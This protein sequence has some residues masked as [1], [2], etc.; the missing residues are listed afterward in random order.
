MRIGMSDEQRK[1]E[2]S[3][4]DAFYKHL[5]SGIPVAVDV[6]YEQPDFLA[7]YMTGRTE[8][9]K[10]LNLPLTMD[11]R[12][13]NIE[14][15]CQSNRGALSRAMDNL[16]DMCDQ[17]PWTENSRKQQ[18]AS[19]RKHYPP[20]IIKSVDKYKQGE[21]ST[22]SCTE[23]ESSKFV[24]TAIRNQC[25]NE[26]RNPS[27]FVQNNID[28]MMVIYSSERTDQILQ[29]DSDG[30]CSIVSFKHHSYQCPSLQDFDDMNPT[31]SKELNLVSRS[32]DIVDDANPF[33]ISVYESE[34]GIEM[35]SL[36]TSLTA[37]VTDSQESTNYGGCSQDDVTECEVHKIPLGE[38][39]VDNASATLSKTDLPRSTNV[40]GPNTIDAELID[41]PALSLEPNNDVSFDFCT[42]NSIQRRVLFPGV[43]G[44][45]TSND[46]NWK[47][48]NDSSIIQEVHT[49]TSIPAHSKLSDIQCMI[50]DIKDTI[51]AYKCHNESKLM[52]QISPNLDSP[53]LD[54]PVI[55]IDKSPHYNPTRIIDS[56][57]LG[58]PLSLITTPMVMDISLGEEKDNYIADPQCHDK[59]NVGRTGADEFMD[60][61]VDIDKKYN[62]QSVLLSE[63]QNFAVLKSFWCQKEKRESKRV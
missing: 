36:L 27:S 56:T 55:T 51:S 29:L 4:I 41:S 37:N 49:K 12:T 46:I 44:L 35:D 48:T 50:E 60:E 39:H 34:D 13:C 14:E 3:D 38:E 7:S 43:S 22:I 24:G 59:I 42:R 6:F 16:K 63:K 52:N 9:M 32:R 5:D 1:D 26:H 21:W 33:Q 20:S 11:A 25:G 53:G 47:R 17:V 62:N 10:R 15:D 30:D 8:N 54:L 57:I 45:N 31:E 61:M 58:E 28:Q 18:V 19:A 2:P 40:R 23:K